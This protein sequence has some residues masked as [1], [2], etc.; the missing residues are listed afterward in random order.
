MSLDRLAM[1]QALPGYEIGE[2]IGRGAFGV[3]YRGRHRTLGRDVAIKQLPRAF[4]ADPAMRDRFTSEARLVA[5]FDHPHIVPVYDYVEHEGLRLMVMEYLQDGTL[6]A[7]AGVP[8]NSEHSLTVE[9]SCAIAIAVSL[10]LH[11]AHG[12]GILHRDVKP[13]NVLFAGDTPK[14]ADFGIAKGGDT[15]GLTVTGTVIGTVAYMSPQQASGEALGPSTDVYSCAIMLY[16]LLAGRLPFP[17]VDSLTGQLLQHLTVTPE[18][19][20]ATAPGVPDSVAEVVL[21]G[22]AKQP[23]GRPE[24]AAEFAVQLNAACAASYGPRWLAHSGIRVVGLDTVNAGLRTEAVGAQKIGAPAASAGPETA[25]VP[26]TQGLGARGSAAETVTAAAP[27]RG[28]APR[29]AST[30]GGN[31]VAEEPKRKRRLA[32]AVVAAL[33]VAALV[34]AGLVVVGGGDDSSSEAVNVAV[35]DRP[36]SDTSLLPST[37]TAPTTAVPTTAVP[38]TAPATTVPSAPRTTQSGGTRPR[39][40]MFL[41]IDQA[42]AARGYPGDQCGCIRR[43]ASTLNATQLTTLRDAIERRGQMTPAARRILVT[44]SVSRA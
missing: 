28:V 13:D 29:A 24:S 6:T 17:Q 2:E 27:T 1:E 4:G 12:R 36:S 23:S 25:G 43:Q 37:T 3:V 30:V 9:K 41:A 14:L 10:A 7:R 33:G 31:P 15:S 18:P 32:V 20:S 40:A 8:Q 26:D 38:T 39:D 22:L 35:A 44:C 19:L 21:S 16:E 34:A 5:S 11:H 42:C